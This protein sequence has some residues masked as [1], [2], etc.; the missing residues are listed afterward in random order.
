D[1]SGIAFP[2]HRAIL[3]KHANECEHPHRLLS[4]L[5]EEL[6]AEVAV[7]E[8][9]A[10]PWQQRDHAA[11]RGDLVHTAIAAVALGQPIGELPVAASRVLASFQRFLADHRP[12]FVA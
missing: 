10:A 9:K 11:D 3:A 5:L 12:R 8:I 2:L 4:R 1:A 7:K 6:P